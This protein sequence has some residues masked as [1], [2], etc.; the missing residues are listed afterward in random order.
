MG[1]GSHPEGSVKINID[2]SVRLGENFIGIGVAFQDNAGV[3]LATCAKRIAGSFE[4]ETDELLAIREGLLLAKEW[5]ILVHIVE[6]SVLLIVQ[7]INAASPLAI[8]ETLISD[9][10]HLCKF[11]NCGPFCFVS[12][13]GNNVAQALANHASIYPEDM[14][15]VDC[16][17]RFISSFVLYRHLF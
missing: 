4:V 15:W 13:N 12:R 17:P 9:I 3:V 8:Y 6:S 11:V 10:K 1:D 7:G 2:A 14:L 16:S 5:S